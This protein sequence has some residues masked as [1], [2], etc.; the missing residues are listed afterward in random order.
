MLS[1]CGQRTIQS[2]A[3]LNGLHPGVAVVGQ[4]REGLEGLVEIAYNLAQ[5]SAVVGPGPSLLAVEHGL[6]PHLAP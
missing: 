5:C 1:H 2:E 4:V 6:V 3:E